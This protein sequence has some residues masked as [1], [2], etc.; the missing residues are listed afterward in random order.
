MDEAMYILNRLI[1]CEAYAMTTF[2]NAHRLHISTTSGSKQ[3]SKNVH[4]YQVKDHME[5]P[6]SA[7][8]S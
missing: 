6:F 1:N 3:V 7:Y 8:L 2:A 4:I 5:L